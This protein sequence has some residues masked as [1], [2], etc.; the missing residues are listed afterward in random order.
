MWSEIVRI[1]S[2]TLLIQIQEEIS[3]GYI[4]LAFS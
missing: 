3:Y 2:H 1:F 4:N